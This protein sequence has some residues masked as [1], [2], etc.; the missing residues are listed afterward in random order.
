MTALSVPNNGQ[1]FGGS[2]PYDEAAALPGAATDESTRPVRRSLFAAFRAAVGDTVA[3][4][5]MPATVAAESQPELIAAP[6]TAPIGSDAELV[7]ADAPEEHDEPAAAADVLEAERPVAVAAVTAVVVPDEVALGL[8][9]AEPVA[10]VASQD[11]FVP[12]HEAVAASP[13]AVAASPAAVA[14]SPAAVAASPAAVAASPAAV[15]A[16]PAAVAAS[17]AAIAADPA[18]VVPGPTE[19]ARG[20]VFAGRKAQIRL[21]PSKASTHPTSGRRGDLFVDNAGRLWFCRSGGK[22]ATWKQVKLV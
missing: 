22:T 12:D 20:A 13:A 2:D 11:A 8:T 7:A 15:A 18:A 14:A 3:P 1:A 4:V 21:S 5:A 6:A 10:A 9:E 17:P 19:P 16:S